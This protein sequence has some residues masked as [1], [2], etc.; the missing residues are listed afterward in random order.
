MN[1][2]ILTLTI[3][4]GEELVYTSGTGGNADPRTPP[5]SYPATSP[6]PT[7]SMQTSTNVTFVAGVMTV[8]KARRRFMGIWS[9]LLTVTY[10]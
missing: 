3:S 2:N 4:P 7:V 6:A 5:P 8:V 10:P 1:G 9:E